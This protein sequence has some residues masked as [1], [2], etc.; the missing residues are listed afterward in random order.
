VDKDKSVHP[1]KRPITFKEAA[2]AGFSE[3]RKY[4]ILRASRH[5]QHQAAFAKCE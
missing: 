4:G 5:Y 1:E 3:I 2:N